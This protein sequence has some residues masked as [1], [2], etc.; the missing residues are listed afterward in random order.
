MKQ[1]E[2]YCCSFRYTSH[3]T[4]ACHVHK[5]IPCTHD[6]IS[7]IPA[8]TRCDGLVCTQYIM[9]LIILLIHVDI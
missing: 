5:T 9:N 3:K 2:I 8:N 7:N 4:I 6:T 1:G